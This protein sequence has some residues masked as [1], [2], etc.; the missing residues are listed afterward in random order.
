MALSSRLFRYAGALAAYWREASLLVASVVATL[1]VLEIG[2]RLYQHQ[3]LPGRL[4]ALV[5]AQIRADYHARAGH[6]APPLYI[7]DP[8]TGYIYPPN[9]QGQRGHPW[10][11]RWRTNSHGHVSRFEYPRQKSPREYRIAVIGDSMTANITN[12]VR[13]T[14]VLEELLNASPQWRRLVADGF[15]RVINFGVDGMGMVQFAAMVRHHVM[16]FEPDMIS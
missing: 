13:W 1:I 11:S 6:G 15:T 16:P 14:E 10:N 2:Y 8:R 9:F 5:E 12:N 3:T 7:P 4:F